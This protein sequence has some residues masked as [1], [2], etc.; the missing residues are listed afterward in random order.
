M[1]QDRTSELGGNRMLRVNGTS[2]ETV[3]GD[4]VLLYRDG[5]AV[6]VDG[7]ASTTV[8]THGDAGKS[9][10]Y[11]FGDHVAGAEGSLTLV[12][13][14]S[15]TFQCGNS[16]IALTPDGLKIGAKSLA[17]AGADGVSLKGKG[18][19]IN[20]TDEAE[21][22][23]KSLKIFSE[24]A[25]LELEKEAHL[26]GERVLLNCDTATP[27]EVDPSTGRTKTKPLKVKLSDV[28]LAAT[29]GKKFKLLV[30]GNVYEGTTGADGTITQ[31]IPEAATSATVLL[32]PDAYPEGPRRQWNLSLR[33][34]PRRPRRQ[35][36]RSGC[37]TSA[38]TA[39]RWA[40]T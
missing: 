32:W 21:I 33:I 37:A 13:K 6:H 9:D 12:A 18:P 4:A 2:K 26:R 40:T 25:S 16:V 17:L 27:P 38:T 22:V 31:E 39:A 34:S 10:F 7:H 24:G 8:G 23:A 3:T 29:A 15:I 28:T 1:E 19:A 14:K 35:G 11:V 30:D 36:Q 5:R 20:L